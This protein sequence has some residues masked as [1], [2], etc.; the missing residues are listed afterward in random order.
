MAS[1]V[2]AYSFDDVQEV[3]NSVDECLE[4]VGALGIGDEGGDECSESG[5][6][7]DEEREGDDRVDECEVSLM[8]RDEP[9]DV[10]YCQKIISYTDMLK[11]FIC[12]LDFL[13]WI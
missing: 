2:I 6:G 7:V 10:P 11:Y 5:D 12:K 3:S 1:P 9:K 8:K 4:S 13:N